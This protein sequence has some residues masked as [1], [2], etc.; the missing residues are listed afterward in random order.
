MSKIKYLHF[1]GTSYTAGGGYEFTTPSKLKK[2]KLFKC[3]GDVDE[4][5]TRYNFSYP[6]Q[7]D[8]LLK[9]R[10]SNIKV[11]NHSK[12]GFGNESLYRKT[13]D[14]VFEDGFNKD[15]HLFLYEFSL[16]GRKEVYSRTIGDYV[17]INYKHLFNEGE[18]N[19]C[20]IYGLGHNYLED[21]QEK[22]DILDRLHQEFNPFIEETVNA[23]KMEILAAH[24]NIMFINFLQNNNLNYV[25][26]QAPWFG[27]GKYFKNKIKS[28]FNDVSTREETLRFT[29]EGHEDIEE[30]FVYFFHNTQLQIA[31]ETRG[32]IEDGHMSLYGSRI[33]AQQTLNQLIDRGFINEEK[34]EEPEK[35]ILFKTSYI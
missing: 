13:L 7:V 6:G 35:P 30:G 32:I 21:G 5:L 27:D 4:E 33:V 2:D 22:I 31:K 34:F 20:K 10:N 14:I 3:Y 29:L 16:L 18:D 8:K 12:S 23:E 11:I 9:S 17:V 26:S 25:Y 24:N 15:E 1:F 19:I 28:F